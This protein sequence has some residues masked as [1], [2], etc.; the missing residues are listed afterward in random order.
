MYILAT[1]SNLLSILHECTCMGRELVEC[2]EEFMVRVVLYTHEPQ[3]NGGICALS[4]PFLN[5]P[6]TLK[7]PRVNLNAPSVLSQ[8]TV[9]QVIVPKIKP[10]Y[11][12]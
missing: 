8:K 9:H 7:S 2:M 4:R 12:S 6:P 3:N 1:A 10:M 11:T 5:C